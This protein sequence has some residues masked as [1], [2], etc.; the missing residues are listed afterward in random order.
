MRFGLIQSEHHF[1]LIECNI[2]SPWYGWKFSHFTLNN[3][4]SLI[5]VALRTLVL[6]LILCHTLYCLVF[7]SF[8][9]EGPSWWSLLYGYWIS[10]WSVLLVVEKRVPGENHR[11]VASH[12][13]T[14][15][16]NVVSSTPR[17]ERD[18]NSQ[19]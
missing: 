18:S 5:I 10:W 17:H 15:S 1:H 8:N 19:L 3:N 4:H 16:H 12:W 9:T 11:P 7:Q 6:I 13:Q 2:F 14:C